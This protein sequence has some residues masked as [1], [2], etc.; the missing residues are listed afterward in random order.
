MVKIAKWLK[1]VAVDYENSKESI[2]AEVMQ[3]CD[4]FPIY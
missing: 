4:N 2:S 3:L 1:A